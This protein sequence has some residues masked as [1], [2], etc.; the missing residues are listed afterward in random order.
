MKTLKSIFTAMALCTAIWGMNSCASGGEEQAAESEAGGSG[1]LAEGASDDEAQ[2][3]EGK[4]VGPVKEISLGAIDPAMAD[5]GKELFEAK[6]TACHKFSDEKYVG[7]GLKDITGRRKPEWIMNMII[8]PEVMTKQD[9]DAQELLGVHMTQ[10]T[11]QNIDEEGAR[12]ILEY[13][14]QM[15]AEMA[16]EAGG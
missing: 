16:S 2:I 5:E 4:G 11:N 3:K 13:F 15:D 12:K 7:P 14:R 9:P 1:F 10:M 6:C 8:N